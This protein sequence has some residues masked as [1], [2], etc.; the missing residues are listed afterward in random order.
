MSLNA[1]IGGVKGLLDG[2]LLFSKF[3]CTCLVEIKVVLT[4]VTFS[5]CYEMFE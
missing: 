3:P 1:L 5:F 4:E 2:P